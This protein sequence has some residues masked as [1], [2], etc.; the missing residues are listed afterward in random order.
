MAQR[1]VVKLNPEN[2]P[3]CCESCGGRLPDA[4]PTYF[5]PDGDPVCWD[6]FMALV[7]AAVGKAV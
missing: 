2:R 7:R 6:C 3:L 4:A 1:F 5:S